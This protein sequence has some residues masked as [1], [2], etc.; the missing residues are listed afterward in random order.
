MS[1]LKAL[2]LVSCCALA[3]APPAKTPVAPLLPGEGLALAAPDGTPYLFGEASREYPMGCLADLLW[4]KLEGVEWESVNVQ[5]TCTGKLQGHDCWKPK[6]HGKVDL[7]KALQEN[8]DNAFMF[9][10]QASVSW[11]LR[12][13]GEGPAR[14]RLEDVFGPFLGD[15]M[16]PGEGLPPIGPAWVGQGDLLR[17]SPASMLG[18]LLDPA[19]DE[20]LR[21]ARRL[22][23]S[24]REA[25][26]K[27]AMWW[28]ETG[29][30]PGSA[31]SKAMTAWAVGG[32]GQV[33]AVLHLPEGKGKADALARFRAIMLVPADK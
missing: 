28:V 7:A 8:C 4:L 14:A 26:Y 19:Q 15:R 29:T 9:W 23:L 12:D 2:L 22:L 25:N 13:Y 21:R 32:N 16:P 24:F 27:Q 30:A 20:V 18:W 10:G 33:V 3:A 5:F 31:T 17:A 11:W 1:I 6:G